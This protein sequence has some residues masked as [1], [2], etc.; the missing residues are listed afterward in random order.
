MQIYTKILCLYFGL[1]LLA[2]VGCGDSKQRDVGPPSFAQPL[3]KATPVQ[4]LVDGPRPQTIAGARVTDIHEL[5][6][7]GGVDDEL[8]CIEG[9]VIR[10]GEI[11]GAPYVN[12]ACPTCGAV[13][14]CEG[15][16]LADFKFG[17]NTRVAIRGRI[18]SNKM[19]AE[20]HPVTQQ[21]ID[22]EIVAE[23]SPADPT[24]SNAF[25]EGGITK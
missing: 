16:A 5:H 9:A 6:T 18:F 15:Y 24:D 14:H 1:T 10:F 22:A 7:K 17:K 25:S 21:Q 23:A 20:S 3:K 4:S 12:L 11:M 13:T 2:F 8:A 19:L